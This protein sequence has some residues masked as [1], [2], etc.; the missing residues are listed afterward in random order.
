LRLILEETKSWDILVATTGFTSRELY[1][2][3]EAKQQDHSNV[4]GHER[5]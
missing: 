4:D 5:E 1:E 2:L 3:R